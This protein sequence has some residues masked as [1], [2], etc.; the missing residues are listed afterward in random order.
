MTDRRKKETEPD[1]NGKVGVVRTVSLIK[2][3]SDENPLENAK[4]DW[5]PLIGQMDLRE[6]STGVGRDTTGVVRERGIM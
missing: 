3:I 2:E 6:W 4:K 5:C 1:T